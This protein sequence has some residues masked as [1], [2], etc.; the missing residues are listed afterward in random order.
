M[1]VITLQVHYSLNLTQSTVDVTML[2]PEHKMTVITWW[3]HYS[4]NLTKSTADLTMLVPEC[5]MTVITWWVHYSLN[6][7]KS[8]ADLTMMVPEHKMT[9]IAW[10]LYY[11]LNLT[12]S[13]ADLTMLIPERMITVIGAYNARTKIYLKISGFNI[14]QSWNTSN[15][16]AQKGRHLSSHYS[17]THSVTVGTIFIVMYCWP[18]I[19]VLCNLVFQ[20]DARFLY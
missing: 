19:L 5:K 11:S 4:L 14:I 6:L 18:C 1:T 16:K 17:T 7:T 3:V 10:W 8:K 12:K 15:L 13:T 9:V 20:L 2:I